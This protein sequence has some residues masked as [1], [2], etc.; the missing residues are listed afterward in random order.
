MR[1]S[2]GYQNDDIGSMFLEKAGSDSCVPGV[3]A[4]RSDGA[5]ITGY[6]G[7]LSLGAGN[8]DNIGACLAKRQGYPVSQ[9]A[10]RSN[11]DDG[12]AR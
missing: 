1:D 4:F 3:R 7:K 12:F 9:S 11:D 6:C 2:T 10:A 8:R 5:S